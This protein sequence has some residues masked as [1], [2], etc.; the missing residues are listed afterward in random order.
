MNIV[1]IGFLFNVCFV[2]VIEIVYSVFV[3]Y[4]RYEFLIPIL[5]W[6]PAFTLAVQNAFA[7]WYY[8]KNSRITKSRI[9]ILTGMG[10]IFCMAGDVF[11]ISS[12]TV[13]L[14]GGM[15]SFMIAYC[16][17]NR[18]IRKLEL[19]ENSK[20]VII[21]IGI[22]IIFATEIFAMI[23]I[24]DSAR[25]SKDFNSVFFIGYIILYTAVMNVSL[26]T[27]WIYLNIKSCKDTHFLSCLGVAMFVISDYTIIYRYLVEDNFVLNILSMLY[28]WTG[29]L[30]INMRTV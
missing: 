24:I 10:M 19:E 5:K 8:E 16:F 29:L 11:L 20:P 30:C 6:I 2:S 3:I 1:Q 27:N 21:L 13:S 18:R 17:F 9:S 7:I 4:F 25:K 15:M 14:I 26:S 23:F 22:T 12:K 28:Y